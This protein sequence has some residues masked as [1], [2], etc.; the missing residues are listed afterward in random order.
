[1]E[2]TIELKK[3]V[4][5]IKKS[6]KNAI[7]YKEYRVLVSD[8]VRNETSTGPNQSSDLTQ[9]TLLND[10]RMRRLDKTTKIPES[11]LEKLLNYTK[12]ITWLVITESWCGDAAQSMP[13][14]NKM[15]KMSSGIEM[16]V[17]LRD[18][19]S[20]L[21]N[22]FLTNGSLSIPKLIAFDK[23]TGEIIGDWGP[24]PSLATKMVNDYKKEHGKLTPEFKQ[25]L[26][27]WYNKNKG[28]NIISDLAE[29][30]V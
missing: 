11:T 10:S 30:L 7:S 9:Y 1:M 29:L 4:E 18:E 6:L 15:A 19:N 8:H 13:V 20:E 17:V 23:N 22:A 14:M 21:M 27:V 28:Q 16:K 12:S 3:P 5:L 26:Q 25:D 24:R 2:K